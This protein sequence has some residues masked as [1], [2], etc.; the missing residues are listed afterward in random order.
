VKIRVSD[1]QAPG[2]YTDVLLDS[3]TGR[4]V[5]SMSLEVR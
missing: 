1:N 3:Q 4:I 2:L 5:G